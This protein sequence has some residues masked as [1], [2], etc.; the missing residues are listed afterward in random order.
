M[1]ISKREL[2]QEVPSSDSPLDTVEALRKDLQQVQESHQASVDTLR[3]ESVTMEQV[4]AIAE[5]WDNAKIGQHV[6]SAISE[7]MGGSIS[8][9][10]HEE[11]VKTLRRDIEEVNNA[12]QE[13][14]RQSVTAEQLQEIASSREQQDSLEL[15]RTE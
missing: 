8:Q 3:R 7:W 10:Q 14:R 5:P 13:L 15:I 9:E 4:K 11:T 12:Q 2:P 6:R 1:G